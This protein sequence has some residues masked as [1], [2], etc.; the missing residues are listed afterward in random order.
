MAERQR[1]AGVLP[2][3]EAPSGRRWLL[4]LYPAGHW[5]FPK[6]HLE[7]GESDRQAAAREL[8]EETRLELNRWDDWFRRKISYDFRYNDVLIHK[9]VVYFAGPVGNRAVRLSHEHEE[10]EWLSDREALRR[11]TYDEERN[12]LADWLSGDRARR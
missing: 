2:R 8:G 6:G 5:G 10:Y 7:A 11:T 12:V 1:S 4:L 9:T 3:F